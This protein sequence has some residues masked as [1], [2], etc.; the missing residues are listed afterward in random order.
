MRHK[1]RASTIWD[2][3]HLI[4]E[5]FPG[6]YKAKCI[7]HTD[8]DSELAPGSVLVILI[9]LLDKTNALYPYQPAVDQA[10]LKSVH[11]YLKPLCSPFVDLLVANPLYEEI[12]I[13]ISVVL[14]QGFDAGFYALQLDLD[15]K[16]LLAPWAFGQ[17]SELSFGG[18]IH[19][20]TVLN[21]VEERPYVDYITAFKWARLVDGAVIG[22][23]PEELA[24]TSARS[25]FVPHPNHD[26][27]IVTPTGGVP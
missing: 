11:N 5:R 8:F 7:S 3:E 6:I 21:F 24:P 26:V 15:L 1:Q 2:F 22:Q 12:R 25:I 16:N 13:E 4:L 19:R 9:P 17:A 20:S 18:K 27:T 14:H 10:M 23:D